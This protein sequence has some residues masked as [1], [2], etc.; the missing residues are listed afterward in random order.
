MSGCNV[1]VV[2]SASD[3]RDFTLGLVVGTSSSA[4]ESSVLPSTYA[5]RCHPIRALSSMDFFS[6]RVLRYIDNDAWV[7]G[8]RGKHGGALLSF[9][10]ALY[11]PQHVPRRIMYMDMH[12]VPLSLPFQH[13]HLRPKTPDQYLP[14]P[15]G[16]ALSWEYQRVAPP[17]RRL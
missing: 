13:S 15:P 5:R 10:S 4:A 1:P 6:R 14:R 7:L 12:H 17:A 11:T 3:C 2:S 16:S 9:E 8:A